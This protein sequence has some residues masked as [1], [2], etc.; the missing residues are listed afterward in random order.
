MIYALIYTMFL[1]FGLTIGNDLYFAF[2]HKA[3][4][5]LDTLASRLVT[6]YS[7]VG[8]FVPDNGTLSYINHGNPLSGT[9][10]FVDV[11]PF[12]TEHIIVG[13]YRDASFPWYLQPFPW[14]TQFFIVP[15]FSLLSSLSNLQPLWTVD[16]LVMVLISCV[17]YTTNKV[18]NRLID[19]R[20]DFV[21]FTGAFAVGI[22]GN[23]YSRKMGGTAFTV[24]VTGVLFLVPV[25]LSYLS[26]VCFLTDVF[27]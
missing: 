7:V 4:D 26:T 17:S 13:C 22:L 19:D 8:E 3:R 6:Q 16:M 5:N 14:W 24:M 9:F 11:D 18:A 2:N 25:S 23:F 12:A 15:L 10:T 1:G 21:S 27:V 20:S